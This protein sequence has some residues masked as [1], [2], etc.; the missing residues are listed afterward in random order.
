MAERSAEPADHFISL[1]ISAIR[2]ASFASE[3]ATA[4][5]YQRQ[6]RTQLGLELRRGTAVGGEML[7]RGMPQ[8]VE[9]PADPVRVED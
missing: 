6:F 3:P 2:K 1:D 4:W 9:G 5:K 8:L 7:E